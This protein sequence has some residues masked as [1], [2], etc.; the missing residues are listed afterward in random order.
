MRLAAQAPV[1]PAPGAGRAIDTP[2]WALGP[3]E[4][5]LLAVHEHL[6]PAGQL[7]CIQV[8]D[9][10]ADVAARDVEDLMG[11]VAGRLRTLGRGGA[12]PDARATAPALLQAALL[13]CAAAVE[14]LR[15]T[16]GHQLARQHQLEQAVFDAQVALLQ[17]RNELAGTQAGERQARHLA[18]HDSLTALP[19][20]LHFCDRLDQALAGEGAAGPT[21]LAVF[22]LDIDG[23]KQVNDAHGHGVGDELLRIVAARLARTVRAQDMVCRLGGDEFAC[24]LL[25]WHSRRQLAQIATKLMAAAAAPLHIDDLQFALHLSIGIAVAPTDGADCAT[26]LKV[27]D[28]AMYRAKRCK[29]GFAFYDPAG[30]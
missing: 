10:A 11:A 2:S 8:A 28:A 6:R 1:P 17:A 13:D 26:L 7:P 24:L 14:Q 27:S 23:F 3:P 16:L 21:A 20:R 15:Q 25:D 4:E 19:N 5:R 9:A 22:Y 30:V 12:P 18:L 29:T